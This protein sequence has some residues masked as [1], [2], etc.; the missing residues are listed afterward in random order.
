[1]EKGS[2]TVQMTE[3]TDTWHLV[4]SSLVGCQV[5]G[6]N[7]TAFSSAKI[8]LDRVRSDQDRHLI[9][10]RKPTSDSIGKAVRKWID[11]SS[12]YAWSFVLL[13]YWNNV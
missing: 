10:L 2:R 9:E 8:G 11:G 5:D 1:M 13:F 7:T 4:R 3:V 12:D 6:T